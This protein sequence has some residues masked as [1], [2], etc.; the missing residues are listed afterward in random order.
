MKTALNRFSELVRN[1]N[2]R[3][4]ADKQPAQVKQ[5]KVVALSALDDIR[6][7]RNP[8]KI[9][10]ALIDT[11]FD[12][13]RGKVFDIRSE[14]FKLLSN[15]S[16]IYIVGQG[17]QLGNPSYKFGL[18]TDMYKRFQN[19]QTGFVADRRLRVYYALVYQEGQI[20]STEQKVKDLVS[21]DESYT[22]IPHSSGNRSEWVF[23]KFDDMKRLVEDLV[24]NIAP[25]FWYEWPQ[26]QKETVQVLEPK[27][28]APQP[29]PPH[30]R[31]VR[32]VRNPV[33]TQAGREIMAAPVVNVMGNNKRKFM[34][35]S[36]PPVK[37]KVVENIDKGA[38]TRWKG[39][40]KGAPESTKQFQEAPEGSKRAVQLNSKLKDFVVIPPKTSL[41]KRPMLPKGWVYADAVKVRGLRENLNP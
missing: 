2:P 40:V 22:S 29:L 23:A 9:K 11:G 30:T 12:D 38:Q 14:D 4:L 16:G 17:G 37:R 26:G 15:V 41:L 34:D 5:L 20:R 13:G 7:A 36:R 27:E 21:R 28:P 3:L 19:Y 31:V 8:E 18:A 1:K 32:A 39:Y 10:Q 33:V 6:K 24:K 25:E 35:G